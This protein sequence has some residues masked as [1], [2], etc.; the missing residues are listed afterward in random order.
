MTTVQQ[1]PPTPAATGIR[2][3][4]VARTGLYALLAANVAAVAYFAA[5]AG[6]GSNALIV[7]G[8]FTGLYASLFMAFQLLLVA[9]LPWLD[10]RIGMDR[11]TNWHR[12]TGFGLL[13]TL[14]GHVVFIAF[15]YADL[16]GT[17]DP[18]N[19]IVNLAETTEGV[20]RAVVA[21]FLI[22][23][24]GGASARWARRRLAYE[25]WHFIHLYTYV[26]VVLA[27]T[28]QV[29][30]GT[31]FTASSA[32]TAYWYTLWGAALGSVA[33][34]RLI[35]PLWR[36]WRHQLR[37]SEV[38][39]ESDNVVSVHITG[40]D[41]DKMPAQ[42][43]Q[44]F[45]WRFLTKDR[46]WQ[47]NPFSLSAAPDGLRLRLTAKAAGDGSA[48]LRHIKPGTRVF[49]EGP[50]GAFTA[51]HRTRTDALLIAGGVGVTPIRALM[52]D[53]TGHAVVIYRVGSERDAVLYDEL[54]DLAHAKGAELHLVTGPP[55]PDRLAPQ[56][57]AA[58]VPDIAER[59][60]FLCGPPPM[61]NAVL[62]TLRELDVPKPQ[63]HFERFSLAG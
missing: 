29:A 11:L 2:P 35:L 1:S 48:G 37:V 9:R 63:I 21:W 23:V 10:R 28:H 46:W 36:N 42:A 20:L 52:E 50:Y 25:T 18:V 58:L 27:F 47:A 45:L 60:V 49:A 3:K 43:G 59:D 15:G 31:T 34:G 30:I 39:P 41:L 32:A 4:V 22:L 5:D 40:R 44:F 7:L 8:R 24:I 53:L 6:F 26:A 14:V 16:A 62:G 61:M 56:G 51:L 33:L 38:V 55:V 54:R 13:W 12:W 17:M 19:Q 57:L